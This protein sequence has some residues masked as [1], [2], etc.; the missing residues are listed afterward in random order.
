MGILKGLITLLQLDISPTCNITMWF[1]SRSLIF[2]HLNSLSHVSKVDKLL[3]GDGYGQH[4]KK[5]VGLRLCFRRAVVGLKARSK[6]NVR[7]NQAVAAL[8]NVKAARR[9]GGHVAQTFQR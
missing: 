8:I 7:D 3:P 6:T 1:V 4:T 2:G 9:P 5:L